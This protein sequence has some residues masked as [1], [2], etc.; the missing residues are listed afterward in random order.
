MAT[1]PVGG[2]WVYEIE[3]FIKGGVTFMFK[4][5]VGNR[6][7]LDFKRTPKRCKL[8]EC[9]IYSPTMHTL[10]VMEK[11]DKRLKTFGVAK[12]VEQCTPLVFLMT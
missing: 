7:A 2:E 11:D 3:G 8:T 12:V 4:D 10:V 1:Y 9:I 6:L 5:A